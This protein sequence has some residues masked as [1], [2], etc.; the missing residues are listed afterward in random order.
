VEKL[1]ARID[2]ILK[3]WVEVAGFRWWKIDIVY[4][5]D[6]SDSSRNVLGTTDTLWAYRSATIEFFLAAIFEQKYTDEQLEDFIVHE[7]S[8]ILVASLVSDESDRDKMEYATEC[9][10]RAL[11]FTKRHKW[12]T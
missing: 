9:V 11:L 12:K 7:L 10:A 5:F 8:H 2:K 3:K 4:T 1:K 6:R